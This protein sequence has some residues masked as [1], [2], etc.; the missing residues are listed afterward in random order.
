M[1]KRCLR[2]NQGAPE[3]ASWSS[4][5]R[6]TTS[7]PCMAARGPL[8]STAGCKERGRWQA[9]LATGS[10]GPPATAARARDRDVGPP[11]AGAVPMNSWSGSSLRVPSPSP[12][13][14]S[15]LHVSLLHAAHLSPFMVRRIH[16]S[17]FH[18]GPSLPPRDPLRVRVGFMTQRIQVREWRRLLH[19]YL[20]LN[21]SIGKNSFLIIETTDIFCVESAFS[22]T[23][24][25]NHMNWKKI[26]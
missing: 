12:R 18:R 13:S 4:T 8:P 5:S 2:T 21:G 9:P 24:I 25:Y 6:V 20:D 15:S 26:T 3:R 19:F 23:W 11:R 10:S 1:R 7:W 14:L 16:A 22:N 17:P